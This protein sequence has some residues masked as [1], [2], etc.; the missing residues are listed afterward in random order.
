VLGNVVVKALVRMTMK[1]GNIQRRRSPPGRRAS[2]DW[3]RAVSARPGV[4]GAHR[5]GQ[6]TGSIEGTGIGLAISKRLAE[7]MNGTV[8]F[9]RACRRRP[10]CLRAAKAKGQLADRDAGPRYLVVYIENNP[11][12]IALMTDLLEDYERVEL[13]TAPTAEI[14]LELVRARRLHA[15]IMDKRRGS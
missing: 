11:W 14:G 6:E 5:A 15:V 1:E 7:L 3:G 8:G 12:S 13:L 9:T 4:R 10:P 2:R